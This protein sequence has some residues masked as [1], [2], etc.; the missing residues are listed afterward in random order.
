[1]QWLIHRVA[2]ADA[3]KPDLNF[4]AG[5][6]VAGV[7]HA[8]GVL[9]DGLLANQTPAGMKA[10][11]APKVNGVRNLEQYSRFAP[12]AAINLFSSVAASLGSGGQANYAAANSVMDAW[13]RSQSSQASRPSLFLHLYCLTTEAVFACLLKLLS[14]ES[15][16]NCL[17]ERSH[18]L[19][20]LN[21]VLVHC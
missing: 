10:V 12:L 17:F 6:H 18:R 9:S 8:G 14:V 21:F 19:S 15:L 1:M 13:S 4:Q 7:L 2:A 16:L 3:P 20:D 5:P 11:F